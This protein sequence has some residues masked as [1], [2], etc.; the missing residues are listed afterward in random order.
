MRTEELINGLNAP[1]K[2]ER[3][4]NLKELVALHKSG[5]LPMPTDGGY[6][7]SHIHTTYSFS[8]YY[9]TK[10][11][12]MAWINGLTTAGIVDHDSVSGCREFIEAGE[13]VGMITTIGVECRVSFK[14]TPFKDRR[15]NNPD[16]IAC[17][18]VLAH[19]IPHQSIDKVTEFLKP[20]RLAR[21]E[22]NKKMIANINRFI[23]GSGIVLDFEKDIVPL[24][25]WDEGG[26]VTERHLLYGLA[27]KIVEVCGKGQKVIDFLAD[28]FGLALSEK[29]IKQMLDLEYPYYEYDLLGIL[30][31][32]L[33]EKI[34]VDATDECPDVKDFLAAVK[35]FGAVSAYAY[36]GDVGDSVTG[37]KKTQKFEDDFLDE[38][39]P[40]VKELGFNALAYMPSRNTLAQLERLMKL[41]KENDLF[42]IS[43]EDINSPRQAFVNDKI[44]EEPFQH[45]ITATWT[46]IGHEKQATQDLE[47][48]MFTEK[49]MKQYPSIEE[50]IEYFSECGKN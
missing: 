18:Y 30:K 9:P 11:V 26:S 2:E 4:A 41:C 45:L 27:T 42:Q 3:L 40:Y 13:I 34:Y 36:L 38:L 20:Y 32:S 23:E 15:L 37:D 44:K 8:P 33:V 10:A 47:D 17:G 46:L 22:R 19:G 7:N 35:E 50:R 25:N 28:K 5:V 49:T 48:G 16:Q 1:K 12:Y 39:I 43:G 21:N 14:N 29:Q 24:S 6:V 31:G